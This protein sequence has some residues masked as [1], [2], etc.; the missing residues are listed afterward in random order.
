LR[1][2]PNLLWAGVQLPRLSTPIADTSLGGRRFSFI[3]HLSVIFSL[4]LR[5]VFSPYLNFSKCVSLFSACALVC[6]HHE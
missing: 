6:F 5:R 3:F 2:C 4:C 1:G